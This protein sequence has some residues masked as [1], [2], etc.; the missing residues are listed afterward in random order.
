MPGW[1]VR[2][3]PAALREASTARGGARHVDQK[4]S[5][6]A[7]TVVY[8]RAR[9]TDRR[10]GLVRRTSPTSSPTSRPST[11]RD[12]KRAERSACVCVEALPFSAAARCVAKAL[13][14]FS[15]IVQERRAD[16][17]PRPSAPRLLGSPAGVARQQRRRAG[18]AGPAASPAA[19]PRRV[20]RSDPPVQTF[21]TPAMSLLTTSWASPYT[22]RVLSA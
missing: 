15:H 3:D 4:E 5:T 6:L 18:E 13:T 7:G 10:F 2:R 8:P 12:R 11:G 22:M 14:F 19:A 1:C 20:C 21:L 9:A 16:G 17:R